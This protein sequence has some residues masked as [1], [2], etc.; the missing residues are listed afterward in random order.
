MVFLT[1]C[2]LT[3]VITICIY[4]AI[5][6]YIRHY[7]IFLQRFTWV[8]VV[9]NDNPHEP[10]EFSGFQDLWNT[11]FLMYNYQLIVFKLSSWKS[12]T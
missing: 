1:K 11:G 6:S 3:I 5:L 10:W 12:Y 9:Y 8:P 7:Y 2:H 4:M